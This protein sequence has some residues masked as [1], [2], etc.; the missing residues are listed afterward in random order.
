M[1]MVGQRMSFN[2]GSMIALVRSVY[3][4]GRLSENGINQ[5]QFA[6]FQSRI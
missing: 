2:A 4:F 6:P 1:Y 5:Q 3:G